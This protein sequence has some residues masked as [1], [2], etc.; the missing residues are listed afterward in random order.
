M[1]DVKAHSAA[2]GVTRGELVAWHIGKYRVANSP[3]GTQHSMIQKMHGTALRA[4]LTTA[5]GSGRA[6]IENQPRHELGHDITA[7]RGS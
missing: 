2:S 6:L 1:Q 5:L 4:A 7:D 3:A